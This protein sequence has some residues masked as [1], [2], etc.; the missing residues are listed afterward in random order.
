[1][2]LRKSCPRQQHK[3]M[4]IVMNGSEH[5]LKK[6]IEQEERYDKRKRKREINKRFRQTEVST[7]GKGAYK[8]TTHKFNS[9]S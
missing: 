6:I 3:R 4:T 1:M 5:R 9:L 2:P 7:S 8:K